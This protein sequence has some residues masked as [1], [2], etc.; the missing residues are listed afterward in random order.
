MAYFSRCSD[1]GFKVGCMFVALPIATSRC[2]VNG[3]MKEALLGP[4]GLSWAASG[5]YSYQPKLTIK[6]NGK[7]MFLAKGTNNPEGMLRFGV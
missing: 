4:P 5:G 1:L 6:T 3:V 7:C 2:E